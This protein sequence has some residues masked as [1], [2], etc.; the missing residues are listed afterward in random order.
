M[1]YYNQPLGDVPRVKGLHQGPRVHVSG[2]AHHTAIPKGPQNRSGAM[3]G[4]LP[5]MRDVRRSMAAQGMNAEGHIT[6]S[7]RG[8]KPRSRGAAP[9]PFAP[10]QMPLQPMIPFID[11]A[12]IPPEQF[13]VP[14]VPAASG[15]TLGEYGNAT[16]GIVP[17]YGLGGG[18]VIYGTG[19]EGLG[20]FSLKKLVKGVSK[21]VKK[22]A[23]PI[24]KGAAAV[25]H[26]AGKI[27]TSKVGQAVLGTA[28]AATG[29]GIPAAAAIMGGTKAVGSLIK[30]GGN[31]KHA[32][33]GAY[34]GALTGAAFGVAGKAFQAVAPG[35]A[36]GAKGFVQ[37]IESKFVQAGKGVV[38]GVESGAKGALHLTEKGVGGV[39]HGAE[40][41]VGGIVH[42]V[43]GVGKAIIGV[44]GSFIPTDR[45]PTGSGINQDTGLPSD[46]ASTAEAAGRAIHGHR[47]PPDMKPRVGY[48][49]QFPRSADDPNGTGIDQTTGQLTQEALGALATG[50]AITPDQLPPDAPP[51]P[52]Y[53]APF[54]GGGGFGAG[55]FG[56]LAAG[57]AGAAAGGALPDLS[58]AGAAAGPAEA[59][60]M[61]PGG[62]GGLFG[63]LNPTMVL[64]GAAAVIF[65]PKI[66]GG[67][68][69]RAPARRAS[70]RRR[71]RSRRR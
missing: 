54:T 38:H 68:S 19:E 4:G 27:V 1:G 20:G 63:S 18:P 25:G 6:G 66:L 61:T 46:E 71:S 60:V 44:P 7:R 37:N 49:G 8:F 39:L 42:G 26:E 69:K 57:A 15:G 28:L 70:S 14:T 52:T 5:T 13:Y 58:A 2:G 9:S 24:Q 21:T 50:A 31:I 32:L 29:V 12:N 55:D 22:I 34:Q 16:R 65:L 43:A 17:M 62:L 35:K 23:S 67:G 56:S 10:P 33:T 59:G 64:A 45:D 51:P 11:V 48:Q 30:P 47:L 41:V 53:T 36:A 40:K 3:V